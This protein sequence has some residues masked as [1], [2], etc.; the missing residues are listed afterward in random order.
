MIL[1]TVGSPK[2]GFDRAVRLVDELKIEGKVRDRVVA[3]IGNGSY[4]PKKIEQV[5]RF[6]SW[7]EI[8]RLNRNAEMI[9]SHA[10]AG[11]IMTALKYGRPMICMPRLKELGEHNDNHQLEVA[12]T[13]KNEG[14]VLVANDKS[15]L[16]ECI[17][18]IKKGWKPKTAK[19]GGR[20]AEEVS[21]F[22]S[23]V[24]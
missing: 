21:K 10:G 20:A 8:N 3:Q 12:A 5:F 16:L 11:T 6:K 22:L 9:V 4:E 19:T 24:E 14:K 15:E 17:N 23:S 2:E 18:K 1:V 13:L 7:E